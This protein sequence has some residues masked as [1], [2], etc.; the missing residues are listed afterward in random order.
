MNGKKVH[1]E[2]FACR[3][4]KLI[5]ENNETIY[6]MAE[7]VHLTPA[8]ISRYTTADMA[9]KITTVEALARYFNVSPVWLM[10]YDVP[11]H[12]ECED[13]SASGKEN[14]STIL[15][16]KRNQAGLSVND[17]VEKLEERGIQ[18][19]NKTIYGWESG[20]RQPES[21]I[22]IELCG[23]YGIRYINE[24]TDDNSEPWLSSDEQKII[25][26]YR[27]LSGAG[28]TMLAGTANNLVR[29]EKNLMEQVVD[30]QAAT[31][32]LMPVYLSGAAAGTPLP[33]ATDEYDI[34]M[35]SAP[36]GTDFG[37]KLSGD[38]MEPEYPDGCIVWVSAQE[39]LESGNIG[40]FGI[41]GDALC[42]KFVL[43]DGKC[44]LESLNPK[45]SPIEITEDM[46]LHVYGKVIGH[47][48]G[49]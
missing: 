20:Q 2:T 15:K 10:G 31:R 26:E 16:Q 44:R 5:E 39:R 45:Y 12:L 24:F 46:D 25:N 8:T 18:V 13:T 42:K 41:A 34:R 30:E 28:K 14:I 7:V 1:K 38:S 48:G 29:Y 23:I 4:K 6:T 36:S 35:A 27:Q 9:P 33:I 47:T 43:D 22:L 49:R 37:I 19:S 11:E 32:E 21:S 17:V 3:L 40:L